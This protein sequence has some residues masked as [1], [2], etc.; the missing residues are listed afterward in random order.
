MINLSVN[1]NK[2]ALLRNQRDIGYPN[3]CDC[4]KTIID[5]G[6]NGIT[7]HPRSDERHITRQDIYDLTSLFEKENWRKHH[8][9]FNIEGYPSDDFLA[10]VG[11]VKPD[12]VTFVPDAP[13]QRT[14]DHGWNVN[15]HYDLLKDITACIQ[16]NN[17]RVSLFIDDDIDMIKALDGV[18]NERI[19]LYTGPY[20]F[21]ITKGKSI[22]DALQSYH[23]AYQQS[24]QQHIAVNAGHDLNLDNLGAFVRALPQI[25]EVSI[26]HAF[27][28]DAL[29][30][31]FKETVK[32]YKD[33]LANI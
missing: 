2:I 10:L 18:G 32:K 8:I 17:T 7:V 4:A 20:A 14:S 21:A 6:A 19:E 29:Y 33:I 11:D 12:Q 31:G 9:E 28:N 27:T 24:L 3:I 30:Y 5:A 13:D 16:A 22:D 26:G 1:I 25:K 23:S 15:T